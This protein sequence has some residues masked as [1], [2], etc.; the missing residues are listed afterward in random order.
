MIKRRQL[1]AGTAALAACSML[2][3]PAAYAQSEKPLRIIV[4]FPAGIAADVVTRIVAEKMKDELKRPIVIDNKPGAGGRLAAEV[5]KNSLSDGNTL[6]LAPVVVPVLAPLVFNKLNYNPEVDFTPVGRVC[7]FGFALAVPASSPVKTLKE[8]G[9]WIKTN[10]QNATFGSPAAGS[11]PH[12]FGV[13]IGDALGV[14][15]VH[16]PFNGGAGL[17]TAILGGHVPAGIDV[18]FEWLQNAKAGRVRVLATSGTSRSPVMPDV[19]TFKEQ[20]YSD[21]VGSGWMALYAPTQTP[22]DQIEVFNRALNKVL[23]LPEIKERFLALGLE[24]GGGSDKD[25]VKKM[26]EDTQ[27]WGRVVKRSGFRAD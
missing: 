16:A 22:A 26:H 9:A 20:G 17:Q 4:G 23:A 6:M 12:F 8:Y 19:P 25:L 11:L 3:T 1:L 24:T 15:M 10:P 13:M 18:I 7:D 21:I 2:T 14:N 5:L 27:R